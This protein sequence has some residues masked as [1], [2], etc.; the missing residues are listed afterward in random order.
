MLIIFREMQESYI[1]QY[2]EILSTDAPDIVKN[3][4]KKKIENPALSF[5]EIP[6]L[7][8]KPGG[9]VPLYLDVYSWQKRCAPVTVVL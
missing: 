9:P 7:D 5:G 8:W 4:A 2:K 3:I 1:F 6:R